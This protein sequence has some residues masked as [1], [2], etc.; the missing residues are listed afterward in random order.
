MGIKPKD[1]KQIAANLE[2]IAAQFNEVDII[3]VG[4]AFDLFSSTYPEI[5][6]LTDDKKH[7]SPNGSYQIVFGL[8]P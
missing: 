1:S 2:S 6:L 3:A 7:P 4:Q 5:K 8:S